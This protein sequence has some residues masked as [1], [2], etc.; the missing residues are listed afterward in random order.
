MKKVFL[1]T[2]NICLNRGWSRLC[3][4]MRKFTK[5]KRSGLDR[6]FSFCRFSSRFLYCAYFDNKAWLIRCFWVQHIIPY[7][8]YH[9]YMHHTKHQ[10]KYLMPNLFSKV[11]IIWKTNGKPGLVPWRTSKKIQTQHP[12]DGGAIGQIDKFVWRHGGSSSKLI[13][14]AKSMGPP[15]I[16]PDHEQFATWNW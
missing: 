12:R 4:S 11:K 13:T 16:C 6:C 14:L 1:V 15:T 3:D 10:V 5:K 2:K 9:T 7:F 8:L